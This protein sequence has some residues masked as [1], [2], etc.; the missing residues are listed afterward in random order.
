MKIE[1]P[2]SP[3]ESDIGNVTPNEN[4]TA[5]PVSGR[6]P[7]PF[8][9][10]KVHQLNENS[11]DIRSFCL[12]R[13][14]LADIGNEGNVTESARDK[15]VGDL[16]T[17]TPMT[18]HKNNSSDEGT[19][20]IFTGGKGEAVKRGG[21]AVPVPD[22]LSFDPVGDTDTGHE[23]DSKRIQQLEET[24]EFLEEE[25][26]K[27]KAPQDAL[28]KELEELKDCVV[29]MDKEK[30]VVEKRL[31]EKSLEVE[32]MK[33][34]LEEASER[35]A[36]STRR[37][38][39]LQNKVRSLQALL[40]MATSEKESL[41]EFS[42]MERDVERKEREN[43]KRKIQ[44]LEKQKSDMSGGYSHAEV[45]A[46]VAENDTLVRKM[47]YVTKKLSAYQ[48]DLDAATPQIGHLSRELQRW[49]ENF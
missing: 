1:V 16:I 10:K 24:I 36:G 39:A 23:G 31:E 42:R 14:P 4:A 15:V 37:E 26:V 21:V 29:E 40:H 48:A 44:M 25:L 3:W 47:R 27:N 7:T 41:A 11:P 28:E 34:S 35:V 5:K 12:D 32:R 18:G 45:D 38:A 8:R 30:R 13:P 2:L 20:K 9:S 33:V 43:D 6:K 22:L 17:L 19:P 49:F 46:L